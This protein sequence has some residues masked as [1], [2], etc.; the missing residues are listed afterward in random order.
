VQPF[1]SYRGNREKPSNDA[2]TIL[3]SLPRAVIKVKFLI[4]QDKV[5][6]SDFGEVG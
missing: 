5:F 3:P 2:E 1:M 6:I 4:R